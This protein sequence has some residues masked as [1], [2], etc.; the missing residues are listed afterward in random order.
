MKADIKSSLEKVISEVWA[1][2]NFVKA[3]KIIL[4]YLNDSKI[5]E[6][7]KKKMALEIE[8]NV[9]DKTRLDFYLTNALLKYEGMSV[10]NRKVKNI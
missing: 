5:K 2:P 3:K 1:E 4:D 10:N 7:D 9:R 8:F 6:E